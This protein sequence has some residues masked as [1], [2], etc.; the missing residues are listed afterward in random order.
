MTETQT[1]FTFAGHRPFQ[2]TALEMWF[3]LNFKTLLADGRMQGA[4]GGGVWERLAKHS[5]KLKRTEQQHRVVK[6][7]KTH[8]FLL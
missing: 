2:V 8:D 7:V 5:G 3:I 6:L 4:L 1:G